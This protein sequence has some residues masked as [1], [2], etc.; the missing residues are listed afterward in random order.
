M[1]KAQLKSLVSYVLFL[2]LCFFMVSA[3]TTQKIQDPLPVRYQHSLTIELEGSESLQQLETRYGGDVIVWRPE[4]GFAI[5]GFYGASSQSELRLLSNAEA[6]LDVISTPTKNATD[7]ETG[8]AWAG[9]WSAWGSGWSAWGSGGQSPTTLSENLGTWEQ[10]NLLTGQS[11]ASRLGEGVKVAVIDTGIDLHHPA[12]EGKLADASEW[13]DFVDGDNF[14]QEEGEIAD[15]AFGHGTGVAGVILQ[16]APHAKILPLRV[17]NSGGSGDLTSV[18]AAV[19]WAI[20]QDVKIINLS[21]G[22]STEFK[23]LKEMVKYGRK[24]DVLIIASAGNHGEKGLDYPARQAGETISVG[25]VDADDAKSSFSAY[26]KKLELLAPGEFIYTPAPN[27][28]IAHWSGT[29]FAA[30][31]VTGVLALALAEFDGVKLKD[32]EKRLEDTAT[33]VGKLEANKPYKELGKGRLD[34]AAFLTR[35][36]EDYDEAT[37]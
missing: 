25:S 28:Q 13:R 10:I 5:L 19:D 3:C 2:L 4:A 31:M 11:L 9:G 24:N 22:A 17:L 21:L 30:P 7:A 29:S 33:E 37:F 12:F 32:L 6:N 26:G 27:E 34:V 8:L 18:V 16:I 1:K 20:A 35:L 23:A 36:S 15:A 14:P